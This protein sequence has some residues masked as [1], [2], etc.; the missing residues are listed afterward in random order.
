MNVINSTNVKRKNKMEKLSNSKNEVPTKKINAFYAGED[1]VYSTEWK[2]THLNNNV[3]V[4]GSSGSG[5]TRGI[6]SPN[7]IQAEGSYVVSDPKGNL[8][9][10][11]GEYLEKRGYVVLKM[12]FIHPEESLRYNCIQKIK[13]TQDV[14]KLAH[15][16]TYAK[17][18]ENSGHSFDPFWDLATQD[19]LC[20]IIGYMYENDEINEKDKNLTMLQGL[21]AENARTER[22]KPIFFDRIKEHN[23]RMLLKTGDESWAWHKYQSFCNCPEKTHN[24]IV[25]TSSTKF[26]SFDSKELRMMTSGNDID[27]ASLGQKKTALFVEV[28]DTDRSMDM[29]V[30]VFY[31]QLMNELCTYADDFC[32]N[33]ELPIHVRFIL[34][35]FA[36]NCH[37]DGFENMISNIRSRNI[38]TML[39]IQSEAQLYAGYHEN[40]CTIIDNCN[41]IIYMGGGNVATARSIAERAN[42]TVNTILNMPIGK[43]WVFRRGDDPVLCDIIDLEEFVD[44][45][46]MCFDNGVLIQKDEIKELI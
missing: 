2:K 24:T 44:T 18:I 45:R 30:N 12:D 20:S 34:D 26:S 39:M 7:L 10:K 16:F 46:G 25:I 4:M 8:Y 15:M 41:T 13:N 11:Y 28:S 19:L 1:K 27:F 43:S 29:L 31:T 36:T 32:D 23:E 6:V 40:A 17:S 37:I 5:K 22:K 21:I 9:K 38:S 3:L 35:D 14:V 42:K 33:S